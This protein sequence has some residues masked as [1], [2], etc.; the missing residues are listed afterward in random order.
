MIPQPEAQVEIR[1]LLKSRGSWIHLVKVLF[2]VCWVWGGTKEKSA[3]LWLR[4]K[5]IM[6]VISKP[7]LSPK[8]GDVQK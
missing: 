4:A 3:F 6:P 8:V 2:L 7:S 5:I 1:S